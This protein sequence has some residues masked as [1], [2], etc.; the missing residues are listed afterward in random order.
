[1]RWENWIEGNQYRN[2]RNEGMTLQEIADATG[3]PE[4]RIRYVLAEYATSRHRG[5]RR[6]SCIYAGL[7][8]WLNENECSVAMLARMIYSDTCNSTLENRLRL[9]LRGDIRMKIDDIDD[10]LAVTGCTY[11]ELFGMEDC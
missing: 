8:K 5:V 2:M 6:A 3:Q 11:E 4:R 7:R 1:M 10:I 9:L